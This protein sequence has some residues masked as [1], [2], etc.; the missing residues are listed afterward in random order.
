MAHGADLLKRCDPG[1]MGTP[2]HQHLLDFTPLLEQELVLDLFGIIR[3]CNAVG[4]IRY[5]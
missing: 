4:I 3:E 5:R 2:S 1:I